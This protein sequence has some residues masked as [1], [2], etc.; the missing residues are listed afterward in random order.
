MTQLARM[1]TLIITT[2]AATLYGQTTDAIVVDQYRLGHLEAATPAD[3]DT[4]QSIVEWRA[5]SPLI[6]YAVSG[7]H[8]WFTGVPGTYTLTQDVL[9]ITVQLTDDGKF[10]R[11]RV[12]RD[13]RTVPITIRGQ[14]PTP[15]TPTTPV[16]PSTK[17]IS[18][19]TYVF[20]KDTTTIPRPVALALQK[21]NAQG[22]MATEFEED[23]RDG[24]DSIPDQYAIPL[25]AA[26]QAGLPAL[27]VQSHFEV[28]RVVKS[29]TTEQQVL[30]AAK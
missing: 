10:Q 11:F 16:D 15:P 5:S 26:Q 30:E 1:L 6:D 28:V 3:T 24:T 14:A 22:I 7:Q 25:A 12:S 8:V 23:T 9:T 21:L 20:E 19:V 27:V 29:P 18:R 13:S 2:L 17:K 4:V